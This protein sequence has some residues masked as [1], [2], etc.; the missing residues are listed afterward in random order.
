M[1]ALQRKLLLSRRY[2]EL[3]GFDGFHEPIANDSRQDFSIRAHQAR[4]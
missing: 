1:V 2:Q 3:R 4:K